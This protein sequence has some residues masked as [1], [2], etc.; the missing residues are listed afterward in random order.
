MKKWQQNTLKKALWENVNKLCN[1]FSILIGCLD[2]TI[3]L[4]SL[5]IGLFQRAK[6]HFTKPF[7]VFSSETKND[8]HVYFEIWCF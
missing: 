8:Q 5:F 6:I 2:R 3:I 7:G 1:G 4:F